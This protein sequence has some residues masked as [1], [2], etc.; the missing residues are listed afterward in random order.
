MN[1]RIRPMSTHIQQTISI[2]YTFF[3]LYF[4]TVMWYKRITHTH[5]CRCRLKKINP[6]SAVLKC[7]AKFQT[8]LI[9]TSF[10]M[11]TI[12]N[13]GH[14]SKNF[15]RVSIQFGIRLITFRTSTWFGLKMGSK[16]NRQQELH[17]RHCVT[18]S[19][20]LIKGKPA[21]FN[22]YITLFALAL[23]PGKNAILFF[24]AFPHLY[25]TKFIYHHVNSVI[26][27]SITHTKKVACG[28]LWCLCQ[29]IRNNSG[30][31]YTKR[32]KWFLFG[33]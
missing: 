2:L 19:F 10:P 3:S 7:D 32:N 29:I 33:S 25:D 18:T 27:A 15:H 22:S 13:F 23:I 24:S 1:E 31:N 20:Q 4:W 17:M 11:W 14:P 12:F 5:T 16:A 21:I 30:L 6:E 28:A 9:I 26:V 8:R